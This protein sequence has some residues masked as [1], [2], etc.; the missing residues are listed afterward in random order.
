[1]TSRNQFTDVFRW[2]TEEEVEA[3]EML[4]C[5]LAMMIPAAIGALVGHFAMGMAAALGGMAVSGPLAG[6]DARGRWAEMGRR[7]LSAGLAAA[8]ATLTGGHGVLTNAAT[9]VLAAIASTAGGYSRPFVVAT[10][11]FILFL[12]IIDGMMAEAGS[13]LEWRSMLALVVLTGMMAAALLTLVLGAAASR[14]KAGAAMAEAGTAQPPPTAQQ[15]RARLKRSLSRLSGWQY[16]IR[17]V[18]CLSIA[19]L[20]DRL[21]PGHH[22]HWIAVTVAILL[23]RQPEPLPVKTTQRACGA[24]LGVSLA[25]LLLVYQPPVWAMVTAVGAIA[26]IRPLLRA[27]NYLAYSIVMTPLVMLIFDAD[28]GLGSDV[29]IDRLMATVAGATLVLV[30]NRLALRLLPEPAPMAAA[31]PSSTR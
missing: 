17:L 13:S 18:A 25:G 7:L 28:G 2:S 1:M 29:L 11:R 26:S 8:A 31:R 15:K 19:A 4:A 6:L 3:V 21:W 14:L 27:R 23:Q 10:T 16:P 24:L 20:A 30:A 5:G 9:I 12:V 22:L